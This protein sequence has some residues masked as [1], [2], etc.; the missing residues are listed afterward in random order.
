MDT[1]LSRIQLLLIVM[2]NNKNILNRRGDEDDSFLESYLGWKIRRLFF[3]EIVRH[4][5]DGFKI[6]QSVGL[7]T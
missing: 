7:A 1:I 3:G 4:A 2:G 6:C 5:V